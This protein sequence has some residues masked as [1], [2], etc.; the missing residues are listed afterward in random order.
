MAVDVDLTR[1][2]F[3]V[4][5]YHRMAEAGIFGEDERVEL[6]EGEIVGT[7]KPIQVS[8][9]SHA[10]CRRFWR[11]DETSGARLGWSESYGGRP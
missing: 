3:T 9:L 8:D 6:I 11:V 2:L 10:Q 5:E 1:R 7:V 4:E